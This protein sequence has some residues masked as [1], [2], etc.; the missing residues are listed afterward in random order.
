MIP[1][2]DLPGLRRPPRVVPAAPAPADEPEA[3][4]PFV[5]DIGALLRF[6]SMMA[7]RGHPVALARMCQDVPYAFERIAQAHATGDETL[8]RLALEL[9]QIFHRRADAGRASR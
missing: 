6:K 1:V 2:H 5:P 8:R 3:M 7:V 4:S 9:F